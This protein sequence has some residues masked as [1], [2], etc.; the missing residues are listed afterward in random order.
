MPEGEGDGPEHAGPFELTQALGEDVGGDARKVRAEVGEPLRPQHQLADD[1]QC[2][3]FAHH[4][5]RPRDAARVAVGTFAGH[6]P[7]LAQL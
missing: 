7:S 6:A 2:P 5:E 3:P 4:I 1:E